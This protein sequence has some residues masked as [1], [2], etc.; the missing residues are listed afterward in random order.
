MRRALVVR[1]LS[2]DLSTLKMEDR[3]LAAPGKSDVKVR[4]P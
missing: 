1:A 3:E 4:A 2:D